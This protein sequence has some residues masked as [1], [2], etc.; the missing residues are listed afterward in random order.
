METDRRR[1]RHI[2]MAVVILRSASGDCQNHMIIRT[3]AG[4]METLMA[5]AIFMMVL[6][7]GLLMVVTA[8]LLVADMSGMD[9]GTGQATDESSDKA[10][11]ARIA[12]MHIETYDTETVP[13]DKQHSAESDKS[14]LHINLQIYKNTRKGQTAEGIKKR[15]AI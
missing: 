4:R 7:A 9:I 8:N 6:A 12:G 14:I 1:Y 10:A 13:Q 3:A 15:E 2:L 5:D 11:S